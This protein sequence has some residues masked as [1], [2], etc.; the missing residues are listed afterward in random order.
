LT[1]FDEVDPPPKP[2]PVERKVSTPKTPLEKWIKSGWCSTPPRWAATLCRVM[3]ELHRAG[4]AGLTDKE[5]CERCG[6]WLVVV[7][8]IANRDR[9]LV[10]EVG[11]R[12]IHVRHVP[13]E[14]YRT[15]LKENGFE[16]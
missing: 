10:V 13:L 12:K 6:E 8:A 15:Y 9:L 7:E 2:K 16:T 3:E 14:T 4:E 11:D 1:L 5:L